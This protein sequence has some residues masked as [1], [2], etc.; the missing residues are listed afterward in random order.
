MVVRATTYE[1]VQLVDVVRYDHER[2]PY[3]P[4]HRFSYVDRQAITRPND[5]P[6]S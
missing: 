1:P 2:K 6:I 5:W 3:T 4:P